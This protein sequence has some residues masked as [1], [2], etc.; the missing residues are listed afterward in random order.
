MEIV[1]FK[2]R[3][4][5]DVDQQEYQRTFE[6]MLELVSEVPGFVGIE[7]YAGEDGGELAVATFESQEAIAKWRNNPEHVITRQRGRE[8]FF[9]SY[10]IT[11]GTVW[12][13]YEWSR[14]QGTAAPPEAV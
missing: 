2:I 8:E 6:R 4:R 9:D 13:H 11:I 12:R 1:L 10:Q 14:D 7:G 3:T 5:A